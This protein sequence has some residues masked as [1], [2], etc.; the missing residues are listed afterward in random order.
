MSAI[1]TKKVLFII[2]DL[3]MG[4]AQRVLSIVMRELVRSGYTVSLVTNHSDATDFYITGDNVTRFSTGISTPSRNIAQA[5]NSNLKRIKT[6]RSV[7]TE[8]SPD[9]VFS[10]MTETNILTILASLFTGKRVI[11]SERS[12]PEKDKKSFIWQL[13]RKITYSKASIV[14]TNSKAALEYMKRFVRKE[15]LV[16][17][18][19]PIDGCIELRTTHEDAESESILLVVARLHHAKGIDILIDAISLLK[20]RNRSYEVWIAGDGPEMESLMLQ[21]K[22]LDVEDSFRWLGRIDDLIPL[23]KS[24]SLFI[25]PSRREG[26]PNALLEAMSCG[27]PAIISNASPGPLEYVVNGESGLVFES[28]SRNALAD[29]IDELMC[30]EDKRQRMGQKS[31]EIVKPYHITNILPQWEKVLFPRESMSSRSVVN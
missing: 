26:M 9:A 27:L 6:I 28:G 29:A 8:E 15:K 7:I 2:N 30:N 31:T 24:A 11:V 13:L 18:P 19:N 16:Y 1:V 17:L 3:R 21:T 10:F 5:V 22:E 14:T 4:G 12:D 25:L 23:Y 20:S